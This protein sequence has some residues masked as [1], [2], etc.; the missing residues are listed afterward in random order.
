MNKFFD[1][2]PNAFGKYAVF[3]KY[4]WTQ[5]ELAFRVCSCL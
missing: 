2:V 1:G 5:Q 4:V 3:V